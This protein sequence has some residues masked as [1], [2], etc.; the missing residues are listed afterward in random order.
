MTI[1]KITISLP[2]SRTVAATASSINKILPVIA[3]K[4]TEQVLAKLNLS[5]QKKKELGEVIQAGIEWD[6]PENWLNQSCRIQFRISAFPQIEEIGKDRGCLEHLKESTAGEASYDRKENKIEIIFVPNPDI[7][8]YYESTKAIFELSVAN[9]G[10]VRKRAAE[11]LGEVLAKTQNT[12]RRKVITEAL[13]LETLNDFDPEVQAAAARAL[14]KLAGCVIKEKQSIQNLNDPA[15]IVVA[16]LSSPQRELFKMVTLAL[17]TAL[18]ERPPILV[19]LAIVE[20]MEKL[21]YKSTRMVEVLMSQIE[22]EPSEMKIAIIKA[23]GTLS[24]GQQAQGVLQKQLKSEESEVRIV[25]INAL[26]EILKRRM[27]SEV[28]F[29]RVKKSDDPYL[30][31][32]A[33]DID[34]RKGKSIELI[35]ELSEKDID[36]TVRAAAQLAL[37][38][39]STC[40]MMGKGSGSSE[41]N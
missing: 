11:L 2:I 22:E 41:R 14:A 27:L 35:Q 6:V 5:E 3:Q 18:L 24:E 15:A 19:R 4:I 1:P 34:N 7:I 33:R 32:L 17:E 12:Q 36:P 21:G 37:N 39:L 20:S 30:E 13:I 9:Q 31:Y 25:A 38:D 8:E 40:G 28:M 16:V 10:E 29:S 26:R 23:L